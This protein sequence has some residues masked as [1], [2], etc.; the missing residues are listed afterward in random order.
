MGN[1]PVP[2][3]EACSPCGHRS[4]ELDRQ[5]TTATP[6]KAQ[7]GPGWAADQ[8]VVSA[9]LVWPKAVAMACHDGKIQTKPALAGWF[10]DCGEF[11]RDCLV[12][13]AFSYFGER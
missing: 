11:V 12:F 6:D 7:E 2:V 10:S 9:F 3:G 8:Q 13:Q 5:V 4:D 1:T